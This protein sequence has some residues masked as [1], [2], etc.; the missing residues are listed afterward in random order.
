[1][2]LSPPPPVVE[3][4]EAQQQQQQQH[5]DETA[6][7]SLSPSGRIGGGKGVTMGKK[8]KSKK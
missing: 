1:M 5:S 4:S 2:S 6:S 3:A 8:G 7:V